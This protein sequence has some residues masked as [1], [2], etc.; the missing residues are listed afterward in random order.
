MG[1]SRKFGIGTRLTCADSVP[2][3]SKMITLATVWKSMRSSSEIWSADRTKIPPG[4]SVRLAVV[5]AAIS[6]MICS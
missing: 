2:R 1:A 6:P 4:R 3:L 5:P